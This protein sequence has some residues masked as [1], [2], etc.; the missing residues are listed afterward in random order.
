MTIIST[1]LTRHE[2]LSSRFSELY[3]RMMASC[4]WAAVMASS[5]SDTAISNALLSSLQASSKVSCAH[6]IPRVQARIRLILIGEWLTLSSFGFGKGFIQ[7]KDCG[8]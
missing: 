5:S 8:F 4:V 2:S 6:E 3:S 7:E 1:E